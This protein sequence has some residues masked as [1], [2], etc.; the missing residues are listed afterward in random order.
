M[1]TAKRPAPNGETDYS[2]KLPSPA[3]PGRG[4]HRSTPRAV[5]ERLW[6]QINRDGEH[7]LW[8]GK[9]R[10][11]HGRIKVRGHTM[12]P[13]RLVYISTIGK[14]PKGHPVSNTCRKPLCCRPEH[15]KLGRNPPLPRPDPEHRRFWSKVEKIDGHLLFRGATLPSGYG[16]FWFEGRIQGAHRV[17]YQITRGKIPKSWYVRQR[18]KI[19][20]CVKP[21]CLVSTQAVG[22]FGL[23]YKIPTAEEISKIREA[24]K[25]PGIIPYSQIA[26]KL[27]VPVDRVSRIARGTYRLAA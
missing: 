19:R 4:W 22:P 1:K 13:R 20:I 9:Q 12:D 10:R 25:E 18:C 21:D 16:R 2:K 23:K 15:L 7:W 24:L 27:G 6:S 11:G 26:R 14:V 5:A 17:S 3:P 8:T